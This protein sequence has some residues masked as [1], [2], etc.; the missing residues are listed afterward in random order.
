MM[1][2]R[3]ELILGIVAECYI[4]TGEA[5]GSKHISEFMGNVSSATVRNEMANLRQLGLIEQLHTSAGSVPTPEG[6][7]YYVDRIM[8]L[9]RLSEGAQKAIDALFNLRNPDPDKVLLKAAESIS[10]ISGLCGICTTIIRQD[11]VVRKVIITPVDERTILITMVAS[12]GVIKSKVCRVDFP[13][14][15]Q[16][17][18]FFRVFT[19]RRM[20]G[21]SLSSLSGEYLHSVSVDLGDYSRVFNPV[22]GT[23]YELVCEMNEGQ[24]FVSGVRNLLKKSELSENAYELLNVLSEGGSLSDTLSRADYGTAVLIGREIGVPTLTKAALVSTTFPI[25]E[26]YRGIIAVVGGQSM[27]YSA[28]VPL[29]DYFGVRL[30][31]LLFDIYNQYE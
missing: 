18:E 12:G 20:M 17:I 5:V 25:A 23:I 3:K 10:N 2:L 13:M 8:K 26:G 9:K 27:D 29:L 15:S 11:V 22:L 31:K 21:R 16:M 19:N 24:Y 7:R 14:N 30:G 6:Y 1:D 4:L 28:V